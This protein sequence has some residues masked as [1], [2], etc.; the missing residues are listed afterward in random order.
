MN[1]SYIESNPK[2]WLRYI[3][4]VK[5]CVVRVNRGI[6]S[7]LKCLQVSTEIIK[8]PSLAPQSLLCKLCSSIICGEKHTH[9]NNT[10][11]VCRNLGREGDLPP[12]SAEWTLHYWE[13]MASSLDEYHQSLSV[14]QLLSTQRKKNIFKIQFM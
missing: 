4:I 11:S 14:L 10:I 5:S 9:S 1:N 7:F 6:H 3:N 8:K 13:M 2:D 12:T